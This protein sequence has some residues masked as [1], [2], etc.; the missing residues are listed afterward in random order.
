ME[1]T[2]F[3]VSAHLGLLVQTVELVSIYVGKELGGG[4]THS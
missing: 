4:V 2:G 1:S 3:A